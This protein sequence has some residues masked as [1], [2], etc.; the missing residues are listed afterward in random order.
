MLTADQNAYLLF[1][2]Q[3]PR[4]PDLLAGVQTT[5]YPEAASQAAR[6]ATVLLT[7]G[8]Q[9]HSILVQPTPTAQGFHLLLACLQIGAVYCAVDNSTAVARRCQRRPAYLTA[10]VED[11][12]D[13]DLQTLLEPDE[14][15]FTLG[16]DGS[17]ATLAFLLEP[18][19][20]VAPCDPSEIAIMDLR[21]PRSVT[22]RQIDSYEALIACWQSLIDME[23]AW[24][25]QNVT[26][27][28]F[29]HTLSML[30]SRMVQMGI[31]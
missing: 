11:T 31:E 6:I 19:F 14:F 26:S 3:G 27:A 5:T 4:I 24:L 10:I 18:T 22:H 8:I 15:E 17:L 23:F 16:D 30:K 9:G 25:V 1:R 13:D 12:Q 28:S 21:R 20:D 2:T 7:F 29:F